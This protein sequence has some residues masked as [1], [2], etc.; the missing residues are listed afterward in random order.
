[1]A[2]LRRLDVVFSHWD[3]SWFQSCV[4]VIWSM[5]CGHRDV[6]PL[7]ILRLSFARR[8]PSTLAAHPTPFY[9]QQSSAIS[10]IIKPV[11]VDVDRAR[12][13]LWAADSFGSIVYLSDDIRMWRVKVEWYWQEKTKN[14]EK[15]P[16]QFPLV[17]HKSHMDWL[18]REPGPPWWQ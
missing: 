9:V 2:Q 5:D 10:I 11:V 15:S 17:H 16:S 13:C 6:P 12:I 4:C 1:M 8:R 3:Q 14:T 7:W 18:G